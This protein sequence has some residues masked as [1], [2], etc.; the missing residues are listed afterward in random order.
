[1]PLKFAKPESRAAEKID[2]R[3]AREAHQR[4]IYRLVTKRDRVCRNCKAKG[5]GLHHHHLRYRS[6]GG[7][8]SEKN[9][10]LLCGRCHADCHG[11]RLHIEGDDARHQLLFVRAN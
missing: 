6:K 4:V 1:M 2:A 7:E 10:L 3:K 11:Y 9:L 5:P 8:D